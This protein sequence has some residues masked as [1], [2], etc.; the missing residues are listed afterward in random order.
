MAAESPIVLPPPKFEHFLLGFPPVA[1]DFG[2][3]LR[4]RDDRRAQPDAAIGVGQQNL[5]EVKPAADVGVHP[6]HRDYVPFAYAILP[7]F[8]S[9]YREHLTSAFYP[10]LF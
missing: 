5:V 4:A 6:R 3:D 2:R 10:L 1:Q 8:Q 9:N 7:I